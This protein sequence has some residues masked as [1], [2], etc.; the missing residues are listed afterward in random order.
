M[1]Q[2]YGRILDALVNGQ[3]GPQDWSRL[4]PEQVGQVC[5]T[6]FRLGATWLSL[7]HVEAHL[8]SDADRQRLVEWMAEWGVGVRWAPVDN[9][10]EHFD[11]MF[12]LDR[13]ADFV[14]DDD[15]ARAETGSSHDKNVDP[16]VAALRD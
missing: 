6:L 12:S 8:L 11:L 15:N 4:R 5:Q 10:P 9:D 2:L 14:T 1:E 16:L 13:V 3:P 7:A